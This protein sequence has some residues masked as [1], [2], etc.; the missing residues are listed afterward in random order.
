MNT[1][2]RNKVIAKLDK[3]LAGITSFEM[4]QYSLK[5]HLLNPIIEKLDN[6][7]NDKSLTDERIE[8]VIGSFLYNKLM[9]IE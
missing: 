1:K 2:N 7:Y 8:F 5:L 4:A 3:V 6:L 9:D